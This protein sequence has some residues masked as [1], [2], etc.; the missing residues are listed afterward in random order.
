[1]T[2]VI[3]S[4]GMTE[5][6]ISVRLDA[7]AERALARLTR[8][9]VSQSQ[10]IRHALVSA[11]RGAWLTQ[12]AEDATRLGASADDRAEIEAVRVFFDEG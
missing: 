5:K 6:A 12:A 10:A 11:A 3:Q 4:L 1:M 2:N 7:E 8:G 9:G